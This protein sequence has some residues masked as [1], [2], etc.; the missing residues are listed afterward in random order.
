MI[1]FVQ[2]EERGVLVA[3]SELDYRRLRTVSAFR[4]TAGSSHHEMANTRRERLSLEERL[5]GRARRELRAAAHW[6]QISSTL[7]R[8]PDFSAKILETRIVPNRV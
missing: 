7:L 2:S 6:G 1:S 3:Q 8:Q 4:L 5:L